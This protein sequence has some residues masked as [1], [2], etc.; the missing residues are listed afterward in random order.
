MDRALTRRV[1]KCRPPVFNAGGRDASS[2][3]D[4]NLAVVDLDQ[5]HGRDA[6]TAFLSIRS[7]LRE[8]DFAVEAGDVELPQRLAN[9]LRVGFAGL[10]NRRHDS[11]D[12]VIAAEA[13]RHAGKLE[14]ALLP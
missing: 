14:S 1:K 12:A 6:L 3:R 2:L 4:D 13:F 8:L 10:L 7:G 5:I 9:C 11:P